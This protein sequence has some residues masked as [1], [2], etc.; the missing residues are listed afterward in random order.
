MECKRIYRSRDEKILG[1]VCGGIANYFNVD[2]VL[3]RLILL[4]FLLL[5]GYTIL[6]YIIAWII[7]PKE[8][9]K[10]CCKTEKESCKTETKVEETKVEETTSVEEQK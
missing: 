6:A 3:I 5:G 8:R 7:I 1:G 10:E 9:K 4:A 2:P